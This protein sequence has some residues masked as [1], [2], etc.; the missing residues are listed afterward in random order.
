MSSWVGQAQSAGLLGERPAV[1]ILRCVHLGELPSPLPGA[2]LSG[3]CLSCEAPAQSQV[4]GDTR[5]NNNSGSGQLSSSGVSSS[6]NYRSS[7]S[8]GAWM[9]R[10]RGVPIC[11]AQGRPTAGASLL[12][13]VLPSL[14]LSRGECW[15]LDCVPQR[16]GLW[17]LH[18]WNCAPGPRSPL[19]VDP[20]P[21]PQELLGGGDPPGAC[22]RSLG[23]S[24]R[25]VWR[26]LP[27]GAV[28]LLVPLGT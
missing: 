3:S 9:L 14:C 12:S 26:A 23:S 15:I 27:W 7:H 10:G 11:T 18:R 6:S 8:A 5:K 4:Q 17:G 13:C 22:S 28:P 2:R 16:S 25:A 20:L 19:H 1:L 21:E 24:A